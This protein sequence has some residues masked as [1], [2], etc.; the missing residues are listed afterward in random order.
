MLTFTDAKIPK[1]A[2]LMNAVAAIKD[3]LLAGTPR[4]QTMQ[5]QRFVN[6]GSSI[7]SL[8]DRD[9]GNGQPKIE[10]LPD[11]GLES[12]RATIRINANSSTTKD[13]PSN[14]KTAFISFLPR[15]FV[16]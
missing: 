11:L 16:D 5:N 8:T 14:G 2:L 7:Q 13:D 10:T 12:G 4:T 6:C 3:D 15:N 9:Q 1:M